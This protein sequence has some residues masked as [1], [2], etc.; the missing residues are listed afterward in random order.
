MK[1]RGQSAMEY[2]MTYG[3]ALILIVAVI[4]GL[5]YIMPKTSTVCTGLTNNMTITAYKLSGSALELEIANGSGKS[6]TGVSVAG[7]CSS[8][9]CA[10]LVGT[11]DASAPL[12]NKFKETLTGSM[13]G[14]VAVD[15]NLSY[16]DGSFDQVAT[17]RCS[18]RV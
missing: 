16:N 12:G 15:L 2:L 5:Y 3:W 13:A 1:N 14:D 18:G 4:V 10:S 9:T 6:I 8:G 7:T 17:G 11:G